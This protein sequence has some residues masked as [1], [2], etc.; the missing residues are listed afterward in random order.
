MADNARVLDV[1][2][3]G[4]DHAAIKDMIEQNFQAQLDPIGTIDEALEIM[5]HSGCDLVLVNRLLADGSDGLELIRQAKRE[6]LTIPV[7]LVSDYAD[8]QS[9][10]VAAGAL[11][12]FGK[13]ALYED[14]TY[15][16]LARMLP[17]KQIRV[18]TEGP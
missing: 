9:A 1:G 5:R 14:A 15:E 2:Q 12:G 10:A 4:A 17:V 6:E 7:I 3:C 13:A 16:R 11:P 8:A 18:T